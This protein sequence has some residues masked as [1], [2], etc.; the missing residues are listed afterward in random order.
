MLEFWS[1]VKIPGCSM[2]CVS[3][4]CNSLALKPVLDRQWSVAVRAPTSAFR[5]LNLLDG[6]LETSEGQPPS[7]RRRSDRRSRPSSYEASSTALR[8]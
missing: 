3:L 6:N 1:S 7:R 8:R 5:L 4:L 2:S